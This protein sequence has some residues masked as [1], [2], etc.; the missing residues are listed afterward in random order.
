MSLNTFGLA[1][2]YALKSMG[3]FLTACSGSTFQFF[4]RAIYPV[5]LLTFVHTYKKVN[6]QLTK[7]KLTTE[8]VNKQQ[9]KVYKQL[10]KSKNRKAL[11]ALRS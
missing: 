8:K 10:N 5:N 11:C 3:R 9:I 1:K 7:S 4:H 2:I 6:K